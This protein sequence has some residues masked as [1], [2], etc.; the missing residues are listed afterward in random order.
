MQRLEVEK[1]W[2][3]SKNGK[4]VCVAGMHGEGSGGRRETGRGH[5][6]EGLKK[7]CRG[8]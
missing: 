7:P 4:E 8:C 5:V 6:T 2:A 3:L 1:N